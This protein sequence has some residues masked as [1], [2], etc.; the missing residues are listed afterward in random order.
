MIRILDVDSEN[1]QDFWEKIE[2]QIGFRRGSI[3]EKII[4]KSTKAKLK[5]TVIIA[6][7]TAETREKCLK[8]GKLKIK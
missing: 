4:H 7:V 1:E 2:E 3:D 5:G 6:E 8:I